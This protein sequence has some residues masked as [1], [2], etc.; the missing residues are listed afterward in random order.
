LNWSGA[1]EHREKK[2]YYR[3][4]KEKGG[5]NIKFQTIATPNQSTVSF[6]VRIFPQNGNCSL[7]ASKDTQK[8]TEEKKKKMQNESVNVND[9]TQQQHHRSS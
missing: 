9:K 2:V 8:Q 5:T 7:V 6:A 4:A 3:S 1:T